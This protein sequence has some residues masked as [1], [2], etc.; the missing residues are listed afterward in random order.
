MWKYF[1]FLIAVSIIGRLPLGAGYAIAEALGRVAYLVSSGSRR[2]VIGNLRHVMGPQTPERR[3]RAAAIRIFVNVAKYYVDL[4]RMP[5]MDLDQFCEER[6]RYHGF[7]ENVLPAIAEGRGVIV[8]GVHLGNPELCVQGLLPR[9]VKVL[10]LTESLKPARLSRMVDS[11]RSSKGHTFVPVGVAGARLTI[12]RL[13]QGGV[14]CLMGDRDIAG[15]KALLPFFGEETWV[16][17][18]PIELALRTGAV[19]LPSFC[20]RSKG[21]TLDAYT[22]KPLELEST[23]DMERDVRTGTLRFL[24][25]VEPRI[26]ANPDQWVVLESVWD[27][28]RT[29]APSEVAAV[30]QKA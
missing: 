16:P 18:G 27:G 14:V 23:G 6:F 4:A 8:I 15:P 2:N 12:Q 1:V 22:E 21:G 26:R 9:G 29:N 19:V 28:Q 20:I 13:R 7:E 11:L 5:H 17:T 25:R 24:E 30:G 3:L 10:A